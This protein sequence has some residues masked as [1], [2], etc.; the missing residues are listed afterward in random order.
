MT[1]LEDTSVVRLGSSSEV[2]VLA[3]V[4]EGGEDVVFFPLCSSMPFFPFSSLSFCPVS[5]SAMPHK[6]KHM[7]VFAFIDTLLKKKKLLRNSRLSNQPSNTKL[8]IT[9]VIKLAACVTRELE[10]IELS[11]CWLERLTSN[12]ENLV[13]ASIIA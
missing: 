13:T 6:I 4:V 8:L 10:E 1:D 9:I 2:S 11:L 12:I 5:N 7:A 3:S